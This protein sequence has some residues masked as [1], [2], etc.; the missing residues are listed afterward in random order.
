MDE[1]VN[2]TVQSTQEK[3]IFLINCT[4]FIGNTKLLDIC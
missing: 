4:I 3:N 2:Q 1:D